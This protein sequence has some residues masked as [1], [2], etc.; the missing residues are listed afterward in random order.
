MAVNYQDPNKERKAPDAL[1]EELNE[2]ELNEDVLS[3]EELV[4]DMEDE[5]QIK[6][7]SKEDRK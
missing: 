2:I 5:Y 4:M 3:L 7:A 6:G 1:F